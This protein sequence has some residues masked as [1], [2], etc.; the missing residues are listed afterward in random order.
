MAGL[1]FVDNFLDCI[2]NELNDEALSEGAHREGT[3]DD[4]PA[5]KADAR[6]AARSSGAPAVSPAATEGTPPICP[7]TLPQQIADH[8][9]HRIMNG[10]Y[11]PGARL[12]EE[13]LA[14]K[15]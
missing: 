2:A 3:L 12:K 4:Q 13:E 6:A 11:A 9:G 7:L 8:L 14:A 15:R 10:D 1:L 5:D